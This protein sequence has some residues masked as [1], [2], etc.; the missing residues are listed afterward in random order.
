M[1]QRTRGS[2]RTRRPLAL[3][4][5]A[6]GLSLGL[7]V[8]PLG[9]C[10]SPAD[11][12]AAQTPDMAT[13]TLGP[14]EIPL[15]VAQR[16]PGDPSCPDRGDNVLYVGF[17]SRKIT[18]PVEPFEDTNKNKRW[19][20]GEP[21]TDLNGNKKF[22]AFWVAGY[23]IG[24]QATGV[25][26][27]IWARA[28][29]LRQNETT[30]VILAA[31]VVGLFREETY[32]VQKLLDQMYGPKLGVDLLLLHATHNHET[33]DT[34]G[35]WGPDIT[36]W[37]IDAE[38]QKQWR[39]LMAEAV[40]D[41]VQAIKPARV[42]LGSIRVEDGPNG[43]MTQYVADGRQPVVIENTLHAFHFVD[44][45]TTPP[46]PL[47]TLVNWANHPE[48]L[49]GSNQ[50]ITS[51]FPGFLRD[52]MEKQG[53]GPVVYVSGPLGGLLGPGGAAPIDPDTG[54][55]VKE[56]SFLKARLIGEKVA[57]FAMNAL[58]APEATVVEGKQARLT[59]RT[60]EF[61]AHVENAKY[62]YAS[63]LGL[64]RREFCCYDTSR[65][66]SS[67]NPPQVKTM[68][69]YLTLGPASIITNPG[70]LTPELFLG[71]YDGS[72]KG[73]YELLDLKQPNSPDLKLAPKPPYLIDL[74]DGDLRHRMTF[75][76]TGDFL[77]Y[78]LPRFNFVVDE[79]SPYLRDAPGDHYE[80][81]NSLGPRAEA[82]IVGTMR[83]L[84]LDGRQLK[85]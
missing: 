79:T 35:G 84:I 20:E 52:A 16:C 64:F 8:L 44:P 78:I 66:I 74:M 27:P 48:A 49:G 80:E 47:G 65:P 17:A 12:P 25:N 19:D 38:Y 18:P 4:V 68:V 15:K 13:S 53:A 71:G 63:I 60:A 67:E 22:D 62:H 42:T 81:T 23:S 37:G 55:G 14:D 9:G 70:E 77:G 76:L 26:D 2:A 28:I 69:A 31:D 54:K 30:V 43:D 51:D 50:L 40:A 58:A 6:L 24:R 21:F 3:L 32:E 7:G 73:T 33:A 29:A 5:G 36:T 82:E 57:T 85:Q 61:N 39:K 11:P 72:R 1:P 75:G 10:D 45:T 46:T 34:T 59:F 56:G 83:Q 41:A